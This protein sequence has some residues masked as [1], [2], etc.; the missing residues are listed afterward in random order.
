MCDQLGIDT[1]SIGGAISFAMECWQRGMLTA[2]DTDG[3]DLSWGNADSAI[4]LLRKISYREGFG[5]VL[6]EGSHIASEL[7]GRGSI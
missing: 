3:F 6:A 5:N 7:I 2:E 4:E 1:H